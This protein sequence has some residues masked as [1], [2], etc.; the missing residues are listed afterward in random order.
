MN[1][2]AELCHGAAVT[3]VGVGPP[4]N[5]QHGASHTVLQAIY[6]DAIW[7][8]S[9]VPPITTEEGEGYSMLT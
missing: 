5:A 6:R 1:S 7:G 3:A 2:V 4:S 9:Q 8:L